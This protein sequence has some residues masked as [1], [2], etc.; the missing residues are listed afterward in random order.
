[1]FRGKRYEGND[2]E[3][4]QKKKNIDDESFSKLFGSIL[5]IIIATLL[6][7]LIITF[8]DYMNSSN[9]SSENAINASIQSTTVISCDEGSVIIW[10][11]NTIKCDK[12]NTYISG[13][14]NV[15][16]KKIQR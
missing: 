4:K 1:M 13:G 16:G 14:L 6:A 5:L 12:G 3:K 8:N 11:G 9:V 2:V 15:S 7:F 10:H